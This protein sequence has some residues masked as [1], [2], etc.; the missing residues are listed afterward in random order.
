MCSLICVHIS[1]KHS[2]TELQPFSLYTVAANPAVKS[3]SLQKNFIH[4]KQSLY[5]F[6]VL[7]LLMIF[8]HKLA[9][10]LLIKR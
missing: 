3:S 4:N 6:F 7:N 2:C 9:L 5:V 10:V 1:L 8:F